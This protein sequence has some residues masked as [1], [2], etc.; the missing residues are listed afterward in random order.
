MVILNQRFLLYLY[1]LLPT[2]QPPPTEQNQEDTC[3]ENGE[4]VR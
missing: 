1:S 4:A 2:S 3:S